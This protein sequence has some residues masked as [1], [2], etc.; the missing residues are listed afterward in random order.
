MTIESIEKKITDLQAQLKQLEANAIA[1]NGAA[2][3]N[4]ALSNAT[5]HCTAVYRA[6][7]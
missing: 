5:I 1:I 6:S 7:A 4:S 3:L 2:I